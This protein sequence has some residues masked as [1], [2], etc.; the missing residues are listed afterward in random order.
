[1]S[2]DQSINIMFIGVGGQGILTASTILGHA[3]LA[4][5]TKVAMS[6]VHGMAQRGGSVTA[7]IRMGDVHSPLIPAGETDILLSFEP[8]ETL[9]VLEYTSDKTLVIMNDEPIYPFTVSL[10]QE[11]YPSMDEIKAEIERHAGGLISFNALDIAKEA[12][13]SLTVNVA[14]LGALAAT[15]KL[16]FDVEH[17]RKVIS[18]RVPERFI[19][20]NLKA[21]DM[22][23]EKVKGEL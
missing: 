11:P 13:N 15:D 10:G 19:D 20:V 1:M 8:V 22:V 17:L 9:R 12:G 6:E 18:E 4:H 16:P 5:G 7:N 23:L 21:F 3:A 14:M 2:D